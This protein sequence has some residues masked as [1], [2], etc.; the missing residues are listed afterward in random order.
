MK[1]SHLTYHYPK[2][3]KLIFDDLSLNILPGCVNILLGM[4]GAG[5]STLFDIIS[6]LIHTNAT[7]RDAISRSEILYQIQ[8]VPILS[9]IRGKEL[10]ELI[11]CSSGQ[12]RLKDL[13]LQLFHSE[14]KNDSDSMKKAAYIWNTQYG[15]M[16]SGERRWFMILLYCL[17]NKSFYIFDE[18]TAGVDPYSGRQI[19]QQI[20]HLQEQKKKTILYATHRTEDLRYFQHF[21]VHILQHGKIVL[22]ED[23]KNW[24]QACR[25]QNSSFL[26]ALADA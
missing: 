25:N 3:H 19:V 20:S 26:K 2:S 6:G 13:S 9:T 5:K 17:L 8:G 10:A 22:S 14:L 23:E 7:I 24:I 4:N 18:P 12:Y 15:K 1:I 21:R 11:L 16:S